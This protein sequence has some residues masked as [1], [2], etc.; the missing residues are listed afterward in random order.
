[1]NFVNGFHWVLYGFYMGGEIVRL[2]GS[3]WVFVGSYLF[4]SGI[5][6]FPKQFL[7]GTR[8]CRLSGSTWIYSGLYLILSGLLFS[9]KQVLSG[10]RNFTHMG[11]YMSLFKVISDPKRDFNRF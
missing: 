3:T 8:Y 9:S 11:F 10:T 5:L 2:S 1:M 6:M 7:C 4:L